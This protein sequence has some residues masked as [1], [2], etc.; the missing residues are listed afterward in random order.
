MNSLNGLKIVITAGPTVER[1]DPV[2]YITN[3]SSGKMGYALAEAAQKAGGRVLLISGPVSL[4]TPEGVIRI[5]VLSADDML[6]ACQANMP[7]DI[8]ISAAAVADFK[9]L[10]PSTFKIKK[11][12]DN[13]NNIVLHLSKNPDIIKT[14]SESKKTNFTVGFAAETHDIKENAKSK[15]IRKKINL[16]LA[17]D[18]SDES[19]GFNNDENELLAIDDQFNE[20]PFPRAT[21]SKLA[22]EVIDLIIKLH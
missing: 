7:C 18:V 19:I 1:I 2:R 14:I 16:I 3:D 4:P 6:A 20:Y 12:Y 10:S 13:D 11:K 15:I 8:F 5:D 21:K 17:N 22:A 9:V